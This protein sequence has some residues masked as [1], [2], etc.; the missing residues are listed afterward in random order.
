M[1][2]VVVVAGMTMTVMLCGMAFQDGENG[3]FYYTK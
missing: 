2:I 3:I 1:A